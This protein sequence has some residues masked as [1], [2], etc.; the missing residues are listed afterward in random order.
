MLQEGG[1]FQGPRVGSSLTLGNNLSE[2]THADRPRDFVGKGCPARQQQSKGTQENCSA[3]CL[4]VRGF[5]VMELVS[6]LSLANHS[7]SKSYL[8]K[9][10]LLSQDGFQQEGFWEVGRTYELVFPL[11]FWLFTNSSGWWYLV[12]STFLT[13]TTSCFKLTPASVTILPG[14]GGQLL[15]LLYRS[16]DETNIEPWAET[17]NVL[18][19]SWE[20]CFFEWTFEDFKT[21]RQKSQTALRNCSKDA[22][23]QEQK[24]GPGYIRVFATKTR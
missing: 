14:Q 2:E 20:L 19:K 15:P 23:G 17:T 12:S 5:T 9:P 11:S 8:V 18:P 4:P 3:T 21:G 24:E 6:I 16:S 13:R 7:D 1:P 10:T 22:K